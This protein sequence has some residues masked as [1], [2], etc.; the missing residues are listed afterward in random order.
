MKKSFQL[1]V[2]ITLIPKFPKMY[3]AIKPSID[4]INKNFLS[5]TKSIPINYEVFRNTESTK[6]KNLNFS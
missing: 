4:I 3:N 2:K 1:C 5:N 6:E